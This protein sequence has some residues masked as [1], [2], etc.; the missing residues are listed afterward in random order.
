[1][2]GSYGERLRVAHISEWQESR[3]TKTHP[4]NGATNK[5]TSC[6]DSLVLLKHI[7]WGPGGEN[8]DQRLGR[9]DARTRS[10][11]EKKNRVYG[12]LPL[13]PVRFSFARR[14]MVINVLGLE[15]T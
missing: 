10:D 7:S 15:H 4:R 8:L 2:V 12:I 1:M 6:K 13:A 5:D 9:L 11:I 14:F 3:K